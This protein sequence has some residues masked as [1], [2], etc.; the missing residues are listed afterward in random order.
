MS[1]ILKFMPKEPGAVFDDRTTKVLG[2]AF[3]AA[4]RE[5]ADNGQPTLVHEVLAR[6]IIDLASKGERDPVKLKD[7]ALAALARAK[8]RQD[9]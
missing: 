3:D 4:R 9:C 8:P 5:L 1:T 7:A 2:A 6:R